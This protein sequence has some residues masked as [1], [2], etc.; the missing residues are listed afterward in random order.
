MP[1]I[2][3]DICYCL[4]L[5]DDRMVCEKL[6]MNY[7]TYKKL[8]DRLYVYK[9]SIIFDLYDDM[10]NQQQGEEIKEDSPP[11]YPSSVMM[12]IPPAYEDSLTI[13]PLSPPPYYDDVIMSLELNSSTLQRDDYDLHTEP[14]PDF[15]IE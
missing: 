1:V 8:K 14:E 10:L 9:D 13:D 4:Y 6:G 2:R 15:F 7:H 3:N 5:D 12:I 11:L